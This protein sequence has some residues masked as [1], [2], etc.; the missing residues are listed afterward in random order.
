[1]P[2]IAVDKFIGGWYVS[3]FYGCTNDARGNI[4]G[5]T[6]GQLIAVNPGPAPEP[7]STESLD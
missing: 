7:M 6:H 2:I 3:L 5:P 1:M 4:A